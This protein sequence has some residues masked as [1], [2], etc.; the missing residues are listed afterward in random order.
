MNSGIDTLLVM[1]KL[2][3]PSAYSRIE[4]GANR[5]AGAKEGRHHRAGRDVE[6]A[7]QFL[8][9]EIFELAKHQEVP[10]ARRQ[11]GDRAFDSLGAIGPKE[12]GF[13]IRKG[14]VDRVVLLVEQIEFRRR[15]APAFGVTGVPHDP[16]EPGAAAAAGKGAEVPQRP[17]RGVLH[18]VFGVVLVSQEPAGEPV[19]RSK[20]RQHDVV[21]ALARNWQGVW[22]HSATVSAMARTDHRQRPH[23]TR[24]APVR[25]TS[26][27]ELRKSA[28]ATAGNI[29]AAICVLHS[30]GCDASP[31]VAPVTN[32]DLT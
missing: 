8:I 31:V 21:E 2:L 6:Y 23:I 11:C 24:T 28:P 18:G 17:E 9:G 29:S 15:M 32:G 12:L 19:R 3:L 16:H 10:G 26:I 22:C 4:R 5:T 20:M 1:S 25:S 27:Q 7:R 13:R 30:D 14:L